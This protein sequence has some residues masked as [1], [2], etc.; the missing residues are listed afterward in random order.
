[1]AACRFRL[2]NGS[3]WTIDR[4]WIRRLSRSELICALTAAVGWLGR[5]RWASNSRIQKRLDAAIRCVG[6]FF[7][8]N[9][10]GVLYDLERRIRNGPVQPLC[11]I[12]PQQAVRFSPQDE[13]RNADGRVFGSDVADVRRYGLFAELQQRVP[14]SAR[15]YRAGICRDLF[16]R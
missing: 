16:A 5:L 7:L 14:P 15:G 1:M 9:M 12:S 11:Y 3:C 10:A 4:R 13:C 2:L 6:L 8:W